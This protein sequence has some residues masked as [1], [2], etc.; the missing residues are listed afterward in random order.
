[1]KILVFTYSSEIPRHGEEQKKG[2]PT[3]YVDE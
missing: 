1:M 2:F 3:L